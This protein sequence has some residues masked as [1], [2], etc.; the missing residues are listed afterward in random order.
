[1]ALVLQL[2]DKMYLRLAKSQHE[3]D[4]DRLC[5]KVK[6]SDAKV[7]SAEA[8]PAG[9]QAWTVKADHDLVP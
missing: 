5:G 7:V 4:I 2:Y 6:S 3:H 1:M 8:V 9:S